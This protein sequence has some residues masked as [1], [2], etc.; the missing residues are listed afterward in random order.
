MVVVVASDSQSPG[1]HRGRVPFI[2]LDPPRNG[3]SDRV[4]PRQGRLQRRQRRR[5]TF[6]ALPLDGCLR[7]SRSDGGERGAAGPKLERHPPWRTLV[8]ETCVLGTRDPPLRAP[9]D[10]Q[11]G[12]RAS[13]CDA[14]A[15]QS[16]LRHRQRPRPSRRSHLGRRAPTIA[17]RLAHLQTPQRLAE[18]ASGRGDEARVIVSDH[19]ISSHPSTTTP[20]AAR[21]SRL[22]RCSTESLSQW[23]WG[24]HCSVAAAS[25]SPSCWQ[26]SFPTSRR[27]CPAPQA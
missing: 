1:R 9:N 6:D 25:E 26:S 3:D 19:T 7:Q 11:P 24:C 17:V 14:R 21:R 18:M 5:V 10:A 27:A 12:P 2:R 4:V 16:S 8:Q 23:C 15:S 13:R 20:V 22:V